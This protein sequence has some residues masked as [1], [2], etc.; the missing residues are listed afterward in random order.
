MQD[1]EYFRPRQLDEAIAI[2]AEKGERAIPLAGGTNLMVRLKRGRL[3][4]SCLVDV[5]AIPDL[6]GIDSNGET[7]RIGALVTQTELAGSAIIRAQAPVLA[8]A[9]RM[10]AYPEIRN[11][12]TIGGNVC[13]AGR[14]ADLIPPLIALGSALHLASPS[15]QRVLPVADFLLGAGRTALI[16]GELLVSIEVP[17]HG[18]DTACAYVRVS[19]R[20]T[21]GVAA[22]SAA[23]F[24]AAE[25][26][27]CRE[28]RI[29]LGALESKPRLSVEAAGLL[30]GKALDEEVVDAAARLAIEGVSVV[31]DARISAEYRLHMARLAIKQALEEAWTEVNSK[32]ATS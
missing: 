23:V 30:V 7:L 8:R 22:A 9:C 19:T 13:N 17:R 15:G 16:P 20:R 27:L 4:A 26:G 1:L 32:C 21:A 12:G 31:R 6:R 2:L 29:V 10:M 11:R 3:N 18:P 24:L 25:G 28:A 14:A 5:K